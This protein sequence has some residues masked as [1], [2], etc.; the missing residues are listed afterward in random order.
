MK[1]AIYRGKGQIVVEE[2]DKPAVQDAT[3]AVIRVVR[4]CV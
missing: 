2:R 3:G 1:A 4:A